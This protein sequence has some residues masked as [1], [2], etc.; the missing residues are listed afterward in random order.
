[1]QQAVAKKRTFAGL[2]EQASQRRIRPT[3]ESKGLFMPATLPTETPTPQQLRGED[4]ERAFEELA[5]LVQDSVSPLS[6]ESL[7]RE[8]LCGREDDRSGV[9]PLTNTKE[10]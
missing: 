4:L 7:R 6:A 2:T 3:I 5:D 10:T 9:S 1:L 8:N